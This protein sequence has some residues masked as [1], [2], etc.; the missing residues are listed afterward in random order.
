MH[1]EELKQSIMSHPL[2]EYADSEDP[3]VFDIY[4]SDLIA[5]QKKTK[6]LFVSSEKSK[7]DQIINFFKKLYDGDTKEYPQG[8]M[9]LFIPLTESTHYSPEYRTKI[10][11]NHDKFNGEE[12]AVCIGG[13]HNL[14]TV[15]KLK[16]DS[17][18]T[19][20]SLLKGIPA[21]PGMS[22]S[23]L[24]QHIEPNATGVVAMAV[25]QKADQ[26]Y[27]DKRKL[28]LK[29]E[30]RQVIANGEETK[31][32]QDSKEGMWFG[33]VFKNKGGKVLSSQPPTR[34]GMA[35][36]DKVNK[37]L[38]SPPKKRSNFSKVTTP[39]PVQNQNK[40]QTT[41]SIDRTKA[42]T[43]TPTP[44]NPPKQI[45]TIA[46]QSQQA[47]APFC[48]QVEEA[49][50]K[51]NAVNETFN[52]WIINLEKT[53]ESIDNKIDLILES[54]APTARK[55]QRTTENMHCDSDR[56]PSVLAYSSTGVEPENDY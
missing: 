11:F 45:L 27:I 12:A 19:L 14:K 42:F 30:I 36:A 43:L 10:L 39:A 20:Q 25:Y 32:F 18:V 22:K 46:Q 8:S 29:S 3:P 52:S 44:M 21:T 54:L 35:Y 5:S 38:A 28:T 50:R 7:Q 31:V 17:T 4:V 6:M 55:A 16:N 24:F 37:L 13:L 40:P 53:T 47:L 41:I 1:R 26:A 15:I 51:Q 34:A 33:S 2:W 9:M 49:F 48:Q 23:F 56:S